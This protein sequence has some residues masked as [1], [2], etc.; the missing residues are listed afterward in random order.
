MTLLEKSGCN[1][2]KR[3]CASDIS[4]MFQALWWSDSGKQ[5][6]TLDL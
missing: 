5:Y 4:G 1:D 2:H 3:F 6:L